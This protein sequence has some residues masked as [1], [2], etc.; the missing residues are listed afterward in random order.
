MPPNKKRKSCMVPQCSNTSTRNPEKH[1]VSVPL[2][3]EVRKRWLKAARRSVNDISPSS[4]I[5][6][7]EDHFNVS[8][9]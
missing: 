8:L 5:Y 6:C 1:F 9:F 7:C 4:H 2:N 3:K